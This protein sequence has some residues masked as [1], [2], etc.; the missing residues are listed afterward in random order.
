MNF[1]ASLVQP[2]GNVFA[3]GTVGQR[4][5]VVRREIARVFGSIRAS[6]IDVEAVLLGV[7]FLAAQVPLADAGGG[8]AIR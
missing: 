6:K 3:L 7:I 2:I 4:G 5:D 8:V 1:M